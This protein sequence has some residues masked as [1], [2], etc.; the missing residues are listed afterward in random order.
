MNYIRKLIGLIGSI[1]NPPFFIYHTFHYLNIFVP[2]RF[3]DFVFRHNLKQFRN[4]RNL[5]IS[6]YDGSGQVVH[7]DMTSFNG[8]NWMVVT[9]Y[10]YGMEEYENP[11][12]YVGESI[13][14]LQMES[15]PIIK[16][17]EH[18]QGYHLSDPCIAHNSDDIFCF[19]RDSERISYEKE[20]NS[21][22]VLRYNQEIKSWGSPE[23]IVTSEEDALLSPA[24]LFDKGGVCHMYYVSR[25]DGKFSLSYSQLSSGF[26]PN[27]FIPIRVNGLPHGF[28][29][30]HIGIAYR[31]NKDKFE[32]HD[33]S[34]IGLFLL[35]SKN[36]KFRLFLSE[37]IGIGEPWTLGKE[38][39]SSLLKIDDCCFFYKSCFVPY[40]NDI[41]LS[42]VDS[43]T[44][45]RLTIINI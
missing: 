6:T 14:S 8:K 30:W 1:K 40:S 17:E 31:N 35:K 18:N 5:L 44:R 27:A 19:Y 11:C 4:G 13:N 32:E 43:K 42:Y 33:S 15:A 28:D 12:S 41:L 34:L 24:F 2:Y 10:P 45:Y 36:K 29:L 21:L 9:P 23:I 39:G 26:K 16:Q 25:I 3:A 37:S 7:P 38:I 20:R 22:K